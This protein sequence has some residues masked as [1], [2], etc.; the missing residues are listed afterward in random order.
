MDVRDDYL[1]VAGGRRLRVL[2][3]GL[4]HGSS[5]VSGSGAAF[6]AGTD[7][8]VDPVAGPTPLATPEGCLSR[9]K[10]RF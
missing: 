6:A 8:K 1:D 10:T 3:L 9:V 4:H 5:K 2:R 7:N